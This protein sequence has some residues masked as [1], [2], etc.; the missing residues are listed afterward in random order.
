MDFYPAKE[1]RREFQLSVLLCKRKDGGF[2]LKKGFRAKESTAE[3]SEG[4]LRAKTG[5]FLFYSMKRDS[6]HGER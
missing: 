6:F 1:K 4:A 2:P 5:G 3:Q